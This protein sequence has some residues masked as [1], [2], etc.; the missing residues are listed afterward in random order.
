[1]T[2]QTDPTPQGRPRRFGT[3]LPVR[4]PEHLAAE[5]RVRLRYDHGELAGTVVLGRLLNTPRPQLHAVH[6]FG[7]DATIARLPWPDHFDRWAA[8]DDPAL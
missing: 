7:D 8:P 3:W 4:R 6:L 1:M 5:T 2:H